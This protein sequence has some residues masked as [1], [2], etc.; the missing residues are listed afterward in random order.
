[1]AALD[2]SDFQDESAPAAKLT[3][4]DPSAFVRLG[5]GEI[6]AIDLAVQNARCAGCISKIED[7][8]HAM[9]AVRSARLNLSTGRLAVTFSGPDQ[10]ARD[11]VERLTALGYPAQPYAPEEGVDPRTEEE[12]KLLRCMAV[13]GFAMANVM[14]LSVSVWSG[15][16][17][18]EHATRQL[19]HWISAAIALPAAAYAGR[20]F[21]ESAFRSLRARQVNMDVPISLAVFL[22]CGLSVYETAVG[23][24]HAYFDA[25]V[26]LLFFLL[27][28]R[29]LDGRLRA[30]AGRAA[31]D[32]AALQA[33]VAHRVSASGVVRAIPAREV[34]PG[35]TL[36]VATGE[37]LPVDGRILSGAGEVDAALVT[38][39]TDPLTVKVGD[40][41]YSG[42]I[43]LT[44]PL[45]MEATA[46]RDDSLLAEIARLVEA[47]EQSRSRYVRFADRAAKL[48]VPLVHTLAVLT[49]FGWWFIGGDPRAGILN[50]I[51]ALIIT[52]PCALALAVP[53]V[54]VVACGRLYREGVLVKSGDALER[55]ATA[56]SVVFDKTGT[57]TLGR[58][59]LLNGAEIGA[60]VVELA[61]RL[62][63]TSRHP[64]SRAV[65]DAAGMGEVA[66]DVQEAAGGGLS[67][68]VG[69]RQ[70]RFGS[71]GWLQIEAGMDTDDDALEAWL[72]V[73]DGA[74]V[75]FRFRDALRTDAAEAVRQLEARGLAGEMLSGDRPGPAR[76]IAEALQLA[77]WRAQLKPQDKIARIEA[78]EAEGAA[79]LMVGDGLN[80][81]PALAAAHVSV[82]M[83]SAAEIS[84]SSA[85]FVVQGD[86]LT[87]IATAVDVARAAKKRVFEN[88]GLALIYNFIAIPIAVGGFVTPLIA[89][90]AMSASSLIV[91]GN[92][93]RLM[94]R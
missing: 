46:A 10:V 7:G 47:G 33:S 48:Y 74:P 94:K 58:P 79:P 77:R 38:G 87:A 44:A 68:E 71:A 82:S 27:I 53:A 75:R 73:E 57:L 29:Y 22:A 55:L 65:A 93:M 43:N 69:G 9:D 31:R 28:G 88:F 20:P 4:D 21:F 34:S 36:M 80:D 49:F 25:S 64:I 8:L 30:R 70:V 89:A 26:M 50:A 83:G 66:H 63:R 81:A 54:Q 84:R 59:V 11:V 76:K 19:L 3:A 78:L 41:V 52:C 18:M 91:T 62:A 6:K 17:E 61:A 56:G 85:D 37:R 92:A 15:A 24:G 45:T 72:V 35:D 86:R 1:M 14:L 16:G 2:A 90:I 23:H 60:E 5:E 67:G 51:A 32:L 39:E 12:R 42:M 13:A 40:T